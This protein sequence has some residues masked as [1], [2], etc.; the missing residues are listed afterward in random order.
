L[1]VAGSHLLCAGPRPKRAAARSMSP[2]RDSFSLV[3]TSIGVLPKNIRS[4]GWSVSTTLRIAPRVA[5]GSPGPRPTSG[6]ARRGR[7]RRPGSPGCAAPT[8]QPSRS[9][10]RRARSVSRRCRSS[11][12]PAPARWPVPPG[13]RRRPSTVAI[14]AP[15]L[16]RIGRRWGIGVHI[17]PPLWPYR[18]L[19]RS[20]LEGRGR[21]LDT[22]ALG[23]LAATSRGVDCDS[24]SLA[25]RLQPLSEFVD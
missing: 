25:G 13:R 3:A 17:P 8:G 5:V 6:T 2:G 21:A 24:K 22:S 4:G 20:G 19:L 11:R 23:P 15:A 14:S 9:S 1:Q 12:P 18:R 7:R 10:I 16:R